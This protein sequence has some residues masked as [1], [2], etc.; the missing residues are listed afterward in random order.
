[1][2]AA[3]DKVVDVIERQMRRHKTHLKEIEKGSV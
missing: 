2:Y 1:M 3:I